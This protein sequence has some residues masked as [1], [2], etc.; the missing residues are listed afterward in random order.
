MSDW[1]K[2]QE[3]TAKERIRP[4][5]FMVPASVVVCI[6]ES[7]L[8]SEYAIIITGPV[9]LMLTELLFKSRKK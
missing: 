1:Y 6:A 5:Y 4:Y 7:I 8:F 2:F 3:R 9:I